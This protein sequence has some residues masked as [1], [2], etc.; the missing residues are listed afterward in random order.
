MFQSVNKGTLLWKNIHA[1][2]SEF[3]YFVFILHY[4]SSFLLF[5]P[6]FIWNL[7]LIKSGKINIVLR[8]IYKFS[9]D[10][11]VHNLENSEINMNVFVSLN[12]YIFL[13]FYVHSYKCQ[14]IDWKINFLIS[15]HISEY[16]NTNIRIL[17]LLRTEMRIS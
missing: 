2:I 13:Y 17:Q 15:V 5:T 10:K 1:N 12:Q 9:L 8:A 4:I 11:H 7:N 3:P 14:I 6:F 16:I